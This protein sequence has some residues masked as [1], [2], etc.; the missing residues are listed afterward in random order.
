MP[1]LLTIALLLLTFQAAQAQ[2]KPGDV[3]VG[4]DADNYYCLEKSKYEGSAAQQLNLQVCGGRQTVVADQEAIRQL[5]FATDSQ[6]FESF[7]NIAREQK[8]DLKHKIFDALLDQGLEATLISVD[9]AK[10][11]N[12]WNVNKAI[13]TLNS[14]SFGSPTIIAALRR[15]ARLKDKPSIAS[16]Y[17]DFV[18]TVRVAKITW[19]THAE[20]IKDPE[21]S[22]LRLMVGALKIMQGSPELG[23]AV[24]TFEV[25]ENLAYLIYLTGEVDEL[26]QATDKKLL[27]LSDLSMRLKG[28]VASISAARQEWQKV[29]GFATA[30]PVCDQ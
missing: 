22:N 20:I 5:G 21:N 7:E 12:P 4:E 28:H 15:I 23:L 14:N 16:A 2:C 25:S 9:T 18:K 13:E 11:L 8:A 1:Y 19:N 24:T 26:A 27:N 10:S 17:R 30:T 3:L 29:T 6:R